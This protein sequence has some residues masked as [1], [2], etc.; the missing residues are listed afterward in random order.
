MKKFKMSYLL[1][2]FI[3][4][5]PILDAS[6]LLINTYIPDLVISPTLIL[7]PIIPIILLIYIFF[8][9]K[10]YRGKLIIMSLIYLVYGI[11]HLFIT[12]KLIY[13]ISYSTVYEEATY[14]INYTY[15]IY[16]L[17]I[18]YYLNKNN[19]IPDV[20]KYLF[21]MLGEYLLIIYFSIITKTSFSTYP[22]GMGY[23]SYFLSGNSISTILLLL[24][25]TLISKIES[26]SLKEKIGMVI[27]F[28]LLGIYLIF[29]VGTRTG[30]F[31]YLLIVI[32]CLGFSFIIKFFKKKKINKKLI[33]TTIVILITMIVGITVVGSETIERRKLINELNNET[34]DVNTN[35]PGHTTGDTS[36]IVWQIKNGVVKDGYMSEETKEAYLDLYEYANKHQINASNNRLQQL[37]FHVSLIKHQKNIIYILFGNGRSIHYGEMILEMEILSILFNFGIV[38]FIL[39]LGPF[40][41]YLI[42]ILKHTHKKDINTSFLMNIFGF[43]L[44]LGLSLMAGYVFFSSTCA[45]IIC[46]ILNNLQN[47]NIRGVK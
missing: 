46:L 28:L 7:R 32:G 21:L 35:E 2:I 36:V 19:K 13:G 31:G 17:F 33:I 16:L 1:Y 3:L 37:I 39:Y 24:F 20:S 27:V 43:L 6:S 18:I 4:L 25:T 42:S 30:L 26:S 34:I 45:L 12:H 5:C 15:N 44:A 23:R 11:V 9:E 29:L 10:K 40:I 38:G 22:E 41:Y 8:K 47:N 14:V